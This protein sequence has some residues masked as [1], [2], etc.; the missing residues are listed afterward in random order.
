M[1]CIPLISDQFDVRIASVILFWAV[2]SALVYKCIVGFFSTGSHHVLIISIAIIVIPFLP[3]S[4][5][6]FSVGFVIAERNLYLPSAGFVLMVA[7]AMTSLQ[8]I[9]Q[10]THK[11]KYY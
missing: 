10:V 6:L 7:I 1:G 5:I 2:S 9:S 4:N 3:A 11:V 8:S